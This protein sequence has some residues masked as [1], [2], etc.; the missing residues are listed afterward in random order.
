MRLSLVIYGFGRTRL[1][2]PLMTSLRCHL[3][4]ILSLC[5]C[6]QL[7]VAPPREE[8]SSHALGRLSGSLSLTCIPHAVLGSRLCPLGAGVQGPCGQGRWCY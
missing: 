6:T 2:L 8:Q 1:L 4:W 3:A 5:S 7:L